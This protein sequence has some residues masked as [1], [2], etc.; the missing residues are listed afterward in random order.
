[1][2]VRD[3]NYHWITYE[4]RTANCSGYAPRPG[5]QADAVSKIVKLYHDRS[6][7]GRGTCVFVQGLPGS[8]KS[9]LL[10]LCALKTGGSICKTFAPHEPGDTLERLV[11]IAKPSANNPLWVLIDEVDGLIDKVHTCSIK[12]EYKGLA[13]PISVYDK[14][15]WCRF[16]DDVDSDMEHVIVILAT[17]VPKEVI[18]AKDPAYVRAGRVHGSFVV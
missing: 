9:T 7:T 2:F 16:L 5:P 11:R 15:T 14:T 13:V 17:N 8:G 18:D 4:S 1:M 6:T 12:T 3:G 10:K